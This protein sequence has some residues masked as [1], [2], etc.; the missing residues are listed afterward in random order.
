MKRSDWGTHLAWISKESVG[1]EGHD[2]GQEPLVGQV[3]SPLHAVQDHEEC[4]D[5][6]RQVRHQPGREQPELPAHDPSLGRPHRVVDLGR[7]GR[8]CH[9]A[10]NL[11]KI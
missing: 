5:E 1:N 2:V 11:V 7:P 4:R 6:D 3:R 8:V 9:R 10:W